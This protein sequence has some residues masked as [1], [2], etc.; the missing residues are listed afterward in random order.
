MAI[1]DYIP[2]VLEEVLNAGNNV[3]QTDLTEMVWGTSGR[4]N[5]TLTGSL[6]PYMVG[7]G[8]MTMTKSGRSKIFSVTEK[9]KKWYERYV[10]EQEAKR[11]GLE[12]S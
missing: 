8:L 9:G 5:T 7:A 2:C 12:L 10:D 3:K 6:F 4:G 1:I 11:H